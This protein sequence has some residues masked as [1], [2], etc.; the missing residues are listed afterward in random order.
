MTFRSAVAFRRSNASRLV[1]LLVTLVFLA[2]PVQAERLTISGLG[3]EVSSIVSVDD[4]IVRLSITTEAE[5]VPREKVEDLVVDYY[6]KNSELREKF[7]VGDL[8]AFTLNALAGGKIDRSVSGLKAWEQKSSSEAGIRTFVDR[9]MA[10]PRSIELA[11]AFV[12]QAEATSK[13]RGLMLG[14]LANGETT[15]VQAQ[16]E[17]C[18]ADCRSE[19]RKDFLALYLAAIQRGDLTESRAALTKTIVASLGATDQT[20]ILILKAEKLLADLADSARQSD[21]LGMLATAEQIERDADLRKLVAPARDA[22][23]HKM[24]QTLFDQ[25]KANA[26]LELLSAIPPERLS[27][28]THQL[29]E[30]GL[31]AITATPEL[32]LLN[33]EVGAKIKQLFEI[34]PNLKFQYTEKLEALTTDFLGQG[35]IDLAEQLFDVLRV[36]R[37]DPSEANDHLRV[38]LALALN[39]ANRVSG[40]K[41]IL[42]H[43]GTSMSLSDRLRLIVAGV[44]GSP[45]LMVG[46]VLIPL[47]LVSIQL[48]RRRRKVPDPSAAENINDEEDEANAPKGFTGRG[49]GTRGSPEQREYLSLLTK[50]GLP[51]S[52]SLK[53][54]KTA[55]RKKVKSVH[56]D[57]ASSHQSDDFIELNKAYERVLELRGKLGLDA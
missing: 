10:Q 21:N 15:F 5:I 57:A 47:A 40:A 51:P 16:V 12:L 4:Q 43:L 50:L 29:L 7:S 30:R 27:P 41:E 54:I 8:E 52:P 14:R 36:V 34:D 6:F 42:R 45:W 55:Y 22:I 26:A 1:W 28:N 39:A 35:R 17:H 25:G 31:S 46:W 2:P 32:S 23:I 49:T 37:P 24:A 38:D 33:Q 11:K 48:V 9:L 3:F 19:L 44:F 13:L 53:E 20:G 18:A 56:P